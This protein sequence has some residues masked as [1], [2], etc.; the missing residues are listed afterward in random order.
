MDAR[1]IHVEA[2]TT[3]AAMRELRY[4]ATERFGLRATGH[5]ATD[6]IE[7]VLYR[8][9]SSGS[10]RGIRVRREDGVVRP[11]LDVTREETV[12]YCAEHGLPVRIDATNSATARGLIRD[13][14][15]PLLRR[16]HP[17][18]EANLRALGE[19]RPSLPAGPRGVARR[20]PL[21]AGGLTL[22]RPRRRRS[23]RSRVR[24]PAAR[25]LA[26][27]G[28]VDAR[29]RAR[30]SR[31]ANAS[32]GGSSGRAPQESAGSPRGREGTE[33]RAGRRGRSSCAAT[34]SSPSPGSQWHRVGKAQSKRGGAV[35]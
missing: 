21:V 8:I 34:M 33:G 12:A 14:I 29:V 7:T 20:A 10:T 3:E 23:C 15:L 26:R 5:T 28:A 32:T 17:G 9:V 11:L 4:S 22:R 31:S 35:E 1:V 30:G 6:Q 24:H 2:A 18:A 27:M 16:L 19:A 13:E 25:R